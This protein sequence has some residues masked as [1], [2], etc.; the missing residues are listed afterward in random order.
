VT[1]DGRREISA[2]ELQSTW[3]VTQRSALEQS[4]NARTATLGH[5]FG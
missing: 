3:P 4:V 1:V 5:R 2:T